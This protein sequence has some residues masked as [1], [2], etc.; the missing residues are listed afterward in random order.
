MRIERTQA[1]QLA[2]ASFEHE[3]R[4][5]K[6][7]R[8]FGHEL[9]ARYAG[10]RNAWVAYHAGA[11]W[12]GGGNRE[13]TALAHSLDIRLQN[14]TAEVERLRQRWDQHIA[15]A[16]HAEERVCHRI[17]NFERCGECEAC[18]LLDSERDALLTPGCTATDAADEA[19]RAASNRGGR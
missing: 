3:K 1:Q 10:M 19:E 15:A 17:D 14:A 7:Y 2:A 12:M 13:Y 6:P 9:P 5:A 18:I 8:A 16:K 11:T 4:W